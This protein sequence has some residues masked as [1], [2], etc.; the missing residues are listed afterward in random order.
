MATAGR[1]VGP[2]DLPHPLTVGGQE[3]GQPGAV[4][5]GAFHSPGDG[6]AQALGPSQ[7]RGVAGAGGRGH[8]GAKPAPLLVPGGSDVGVLVGVDSDGNPRRWGCA[9][10]VVPSSRATGRVVAPAGWADN[11]ATSLVPTGSYRVTRAR[12]VLLLWRPRRRTDNSDTRHQA[13]GRRGQARVATAPSSRG[14][15]LGPTDLLAGTKPVEPR[16]RPMTATARRP[17]WRPWHGS[18]GRNPGTE[19]PESRVRPTPRPPPG[20]SQVESPS[21]K[22]PSAW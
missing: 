8:G 11:T 19:P 18:T 4:A 5:A 22:R 15:S 12:S 17:A 16:V 1:P 10:V 7:E 2:V 13:G 6:L 20:S 14:H 9:M 3:A 21:A